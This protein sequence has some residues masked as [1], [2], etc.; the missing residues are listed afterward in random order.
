MS[1][2][3][4]SIGDE[5][6]IGQIVNTNAAWMGRKLAEIGIQVDKVLTIGDEIQE[7]KDAIHAGMA[8]AEVTLVTGG[9]GPT[10]DD[11]TKTAVVE[12]FQTRLVFHAEI[13]ARLEAKFRE[14]G[15]EMPR[16]NEGQAWLP[17]GARILPNEVGSAQGM[18]FEKADRWCVVMPGVPRE[19]KYIMENS[20][21]PMLREQRREHYLYYHTWR[22]TGVPES[23]LFEML[24]D[25][26]EIEKYGKLA[27]LP[28][29]TGV[30]IR[31]S[32]SATDAEEAKMRIQSA[33]EI[34]LDKAGKYVYATGDQTLEQVIG[35]MLKQ[36]SQTLAVAESCTGGLLGHKIT[37]VPGS[38]AYFLGGFITYSNQEKVVRLGVHEDTL[39]KYGAVSEETAREMATGVRDV[40][41]ADY[42]LAIT[43]IAGPEGGTPEKPVGLVYIGF[44]SAE[45]V[46]VRK[47]VFSR[48]REMNKERSAYAALQILYRELS[49]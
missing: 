13:L 6:L 19:M 16:V 48:D 12:Y 41:H 4:I 30:D 14:L 31:L 23:R 47:Y 26:S 2:W 43:G 38:S 20:V 25:I 1:A 3:I 27:F 9:L 45:K 44:A 21:L 7:I 35:R 18:L 8:A 39:A 36:R 49:R 17:E 42:G 5:L 33:G 10:H 24:G 28:K 46:R 40:C 11:V 29:Y 34:I 32:F 37:S 22:T 15:L